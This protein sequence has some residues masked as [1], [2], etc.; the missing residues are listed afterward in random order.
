MRECIYEQREIEPS[1]SLDLGDAIEVDESTEHSKE[2]LD[3]LVDSLAQDL[4]RQVVFIQA[5]DKVAHSSC[6]EELKVSSQ[7]ADYLQILLHLLYCHLVQRCHLQVTL[8]GVSL[9]QS[10][11]AVDQEKKKPEE[12]EDFRE[13]T[14][15]LLIKPSGMDVEGLKDDID[16]VKDPVEEVESPRGNICDERELVLADTCDDL[17]SLDLREELQQPEQRASISELLYESEFDYFLT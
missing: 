16:V 8:I 4:K 5:D 7:V 10:L 17:D 15:L 13:L 12:P 2:A 1:I 11:Y 9:P 3:S 6:K 14:Q